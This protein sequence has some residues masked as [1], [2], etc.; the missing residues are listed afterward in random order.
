MHKPTEKDGQHAREL[1]RAPIATRE[2]GE[3]FI[4][5]LGRAGLMFHFEDSPS[6]IV[7]ASGP[8]FT[9]E[10]SP[11]VAARVRELYA[12][13][14]GP[15]PARHCPIGFALGVLAV[16]EGPQPG[17]R[18]RLVRDVDQGQDGY[19]SAGLTGTLESIEYHG[20]DRDSYYWFRLDEHQPEL[21]EW[22]NRLQI[23]DWSE[24][25]GHGHPSEYLEAI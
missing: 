14:W 6:E 20:Q 25:D 10:E 1:M 13:S 21:D 16:L 3:A 17:T 22:D 12:L 11:L 7:N 24:Q 8:V 18:C 2:A 4:W 23:W 5:A 19:Y 9:E 15:D